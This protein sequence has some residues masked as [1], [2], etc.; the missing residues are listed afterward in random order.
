[1]ANTQW[2]MKGQ[3]LKNC[4]C[5][6]GCPCDFNARPSHDYCEGML[7]MNIE[8]GFFGDVDLSGLRWAAVYHWPGALHEGNGT[9]LPV[10]DER[11]DEAQRNA[12]LT[13]LSGQEQDEGTFFHI[14]SQIVT[15]VLEP[16]F[17]P[18][19]IEFDLD[20]RTARFTAPGLFETVSEPIKNPVTGQPHRIHVGM[21]GGFEYSMA[22]IASAAVNKAMGDIA[23]D[24]PHSHSSMANVEHTEHGQVG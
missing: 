23:Y 22:E 21:P 24:W 18:L 2:K 6:F 20:G 12:L 5:D 19:E 3:W 8:E 11:A 7:G 16:R 1:M 10:I 15:T 17:L 13:I 14:V 9:L 4:N